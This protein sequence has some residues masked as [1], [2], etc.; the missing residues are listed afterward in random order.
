MAFDFS[1]DEIRIITA[2]IT[3]E[4]NIAYE[5]TPPPKLSE[6]DKQILRVLFHELCAQQQVC[7]FG[8][9][10]VLMEIGESYS[11]EDGRMQLPPAYFRLM[12]DAV[13][14]FFAELRSSPT[15]ITIVTG[16]PWTKTSEL[17]SRLQAVNDSASNGKSVDDQITSVI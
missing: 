9:N 7:L 11:C 13:A 4:S 5:R 16:L 6:K 12:A 10:S 14:S 3:W 15:E 8:A 1:A 2:A 17:L